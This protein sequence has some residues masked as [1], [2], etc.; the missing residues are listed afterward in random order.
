M[1]KLNLQ[2]IE[3]LLLSSVGDFK[4]VKETGMIQTA[5]NLE[6]QLTF[7]FNITV[8][9]TDFGIPQLSAQVIFRPFYNFDHCTA[10]NLT[11]T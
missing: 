9:A 3:N 8:K 2:R 10:F 6:R 1:K 4:I 11:V 7:S 5:K